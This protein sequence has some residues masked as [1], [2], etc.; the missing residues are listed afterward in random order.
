MLGGDDAVMN[1]WTPPSG[2]TVEHLH[3]DEEQPVH[4]ALV[5]L[6]PG[7]AMAEP[8]THDLIEHIRLLSGGMC[9]VKTL[10]RPGAP[11]ETD[12]VPYDLSA[13]SGHRR[14]EIAAGVPHRIVNCRLE[15]AVY[16][17]T[18]IRPREEQPKGLLRAAADHARAIDDG[19]ELGAPGSEIEQAMGWLDDART[20]VRCGHP[21]EAI[22]ELDGAM[23][24]ILH[25]RSQLAGMV[26]P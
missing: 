18:M 26:T 10:P 20:S 12:E 23:A 19:E 14:I 13:L 6:A 25:A 24:R 21:Q 3:G 5:T 16:V 4:V 22:V 17:A 2:M 9:V 8:E 11:N 1:T 7:A 15:S